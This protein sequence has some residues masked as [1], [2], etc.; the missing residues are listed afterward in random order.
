M[1]RTL[2]KVRRRELLN[3]PGRFIALFLITVLGSGFFAG[4]Q[5][6]APSME[7]TADVFFRETGLPD[8]RL[9][10]DQGIAIEDAQAVRALPE[11][12]DAVPAYRVDVRAAIGTASSNYAIHSLPDSHREAD[13]ARLTLTQGRLPE[14]PDECV[15]DAYSHIR[16]GDVIAVNPD[17]AEAT[18]RLLSERAFT[19]VGL[20]WSADYISIDRGNTNIGN[21]RIANFLYVPE[22]AFDSPYYTELNVA[23][24]NDAQLS[25]FSD[26]YGERTDEASELLS[27]LVQ[28]RAEDRYGKTAEEIAA[29]IDAG[30]AD[31]ANKRSQADAG[32]SAA[33]AELQE[34]EAKLNREEER[35]RQYVSEFNAG[36]ETAAANRKALEDAGNALTASG[37]Q[38]AA[39]RAALAAGRNALG[40]LSLQRD[41]LTAALASATDPAAIAALTEQLGALNA[42]M[43]ELSVRLDAQEGELAAGEQA[44]QDGSARYGESKAR[45]ESA[46]AQLAT[47]ESELAAFRAELDRAAEALTAGR[48]AYE[49]EYASANEA[50]DDARKELDEGRAALNDLPVPAWTVRGREDFPGHTGFRSDADRI[51]R[52]SLLLPWFLF[53]VAA[54]V[55]LTTMTRMVEEHRTR[56]G[57][58]K[59][60]GYRRRS[61]MGIY[62]FYA[63]FIG[64]FGG[65]IGVS[66]GLLIFPR[67]VWNAYATMYRMGEFMPAVAPVPCAVGLLGSTVAISLATAAA[68]RRALDS[69]AASLMRPQAPKPGRR[70]W[71]ERIPFLWRRFTFSQKVTIRN[72]FRYK[73]RFFMTIIG[74]AG[75]TALL[76]TGFGLQDSVD[77]VV[78]LQYGEVSHARA[79]LLLNH[80]SGAAEET[81][82]NAG[83]DGYDIAY[84]HLAAV[85]ASAG[86]RNNNGLV[87]YLYVPEDAEA[88]NGFLS[89]RERRGHKPVL[90]PPAGEAPAAVITERLANAMGV[91]AGDEIAF[92]PP[93]MK[94]VS[95]RVAGVTENYV[96]NY[97]YL[98]SEAYKTL[99]GI[100]P[101][102]TSVALKSDLPEADFNDLLAE[103]VATENVTSAL[104][105]SQLREIMDQVIANMSAVVWLIIV[106]ASALA[107]VVLYNLVNINITERERELATLKVLGFYRREVAAYI[108][109][110]TTTLTIIGI[111]IGLVCGVFLHNYVIASIEVNEVMF[112][113]LILPKSYGFAIAFT[114]GCSLLI[115]LLMLPRLKRID[116]V[117]SLKSVE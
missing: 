96:Y 14:T 80:A 73:K 8:F 18:L 112:A 113:R 97:I 19:V 116:P 16:I 85:D 109:R 102:F 67:V 6:A 23:L 50:L 95:V 37:E 74:V 41:A 42:Q 79:T 104:P 36:K 7:R 12:A 17:N 55:C 9:Y 76:L 31:Y 61:I 103:L 5:S 75:C 111:L 1:I 27:R 54:L 26:A 28:N 72:L 108:F 101:T 106:V 38:L 77:G 33:Q 69:N 91:K 107:L 47:K 34:S 11:V 35:Y 64:L 25:A 70:V 52:M 43:T 98:T 44:F 84:A 82:L 57:V 60:L 83:S 100:A 66:L 81:P 71:P 4:L 88:L 115:G 105:V 59:A 86:S 20:T 90:F 15:A 46:E 29:Q 32:L 13:R 24:A 114:L 94:E 30:E 53:L 51:G 40:E 49:Q 93:D 3:T 62:Q 22:S 78:D 92:S 87:T 68:C 10:C 48:A 56:I 117:G 99:F 110:E 21:G 2:R 89:F 45:L 65:V 39:G 63:W 58:L